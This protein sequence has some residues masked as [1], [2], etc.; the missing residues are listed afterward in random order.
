MIT[1]QLYK[2]SNNFFLQELH[3]STAL[4]YLK[5]ENKQL[6]EKKKNKH[7]F[8]RN[9]TPLVHTGAHHEGKHPI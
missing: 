3:T 4:L 8:C 5:E 1:K 6:K 2:Q 7:V 9:C